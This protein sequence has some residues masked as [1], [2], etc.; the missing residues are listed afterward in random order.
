MKILDGLWA[1]DDVLRSGDEERTDCK[2]CLAEIVA[3]KL[4]MDL[5]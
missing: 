3:Y 4:R 5:V 1:A 2:G